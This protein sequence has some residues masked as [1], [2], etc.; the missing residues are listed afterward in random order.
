PGA[1]KG[2]L[3][4]L[5]TK[6]QA[7]RFPALVPDDAQSATIF[8]IDFEAVLK[9]IEDALQMAGPFLGQPSGEGQPGMLQMAEQQ[10]GISFR[11][12][13]IAPLSGQIIEYERVKKPFSL[14]GSE[15]VLLL[16]LKD[17]QKFQA[18][19][20][21]LLLVVP[22]FKKVEYLGRPLYVF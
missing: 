12:D 4:I 3:K 18:T 13:L 22:V 1:P 14:T 6:P 19:L 2:L 11:Q 8:Q 17:K 7:L 16:E 5:W 10:L 21:K 15:R 20:E 9:G